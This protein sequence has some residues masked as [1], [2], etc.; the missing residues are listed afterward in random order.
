MPQPL[1]PT[2]TNPW[3][4]P[5][6]LLIV[7]HTQAANVAV[8]SQ[9]NAA[10]V[11]DS[12][13]ATI[14][15]LSQEPGGFTFS[16]PS[17]TRS[18]RLPGLQ[19]SMQ[20][21]GSQQRSQL[22]VSPSPESG[23]LTQLAALASSP[24][25]GLL[26]QLAVAAVE[27]GTPVQFGL[28][29]QYVPSSKAVDKDEGLL[30]LGLLTQLM[31]S[32]QLDQGQEG[33]EIREEEEDSQ[34]AELNMDD[35]IQ[36]AGEE[37]AW[38][39]DGCLPG[40]ESEGVDDEHAMR[41]DI[42]RS[43]GGPERALGPFSNEQLDMVAN[44]S[45][46]GSRDGTDPAPP[47][48]SSLRA[49]TASTSE[50]SHQQRVP[51][52]DGGCDLDGGGDGD[53]DATDAVRRGG[54]AAHGG[55]K[56]AIAAPFALLPLS[57]AALGLRRKASGSA[58]VS[59]AQAGTSASLLPPSAPVA[60][61]PM[62]MKPFKRPR[63]QNQERRGLDG[64]STGPGLLQL[65]GAES[66]DP[67]R[68]PLA[69]RGPTDAGGFDHESSE[70]IPLPKPLEEGDTLLPREQP[71]I[72]REEVKELPLPFKESCG[73]LAEVWDV[74]SV[75]SSD[76]EDDMDADVDRSS[77]GDH[78]RGAGDGRPDLDIVLSDVQQHVAGAD[79]SP[80][81]DPP[82]REQMIEALGLN[83]V[84]D[85]ASNDDDQPP[86]LMWEV[87]DSASEQGSE[88]S[89]NDGG[90]KHGALVQAP[91]ISPPALGTTELVPEAAPVIGGPGAIPGAG[92]GLALQRPPSPAL[93]W[94][95]FFPLGNGSTAC[96][97]ST[98]P[99]AAPFSGRSSPVIGASA[100]DYREGGPF[101]AFLRCSV[102]TKAP[103]TAM[104]PGTA[105]PPDSM[106]PGTDFP[107]RTPADVQAVTPPATAVARDLTA[108]LDQQMFLRGDA[109]CMGGMQPREVP[110]QQT[111]EGPSPSP[112]TQ[113][114]GQVERPSGS[115]KRQSIASQED[116]FRGLRGG[117]DAVSS[118]RLEGRDGSSPGG[119]EAGAWGARPAPESLPALPP[120]RLACC[121][122]GLRPREL[123]PTP[124]SAEASISTVHGL[125]RVVH[126]V[127]RFGGVTRLSSQA[128]PPR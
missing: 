61:D 21:N 103:S 29:S 100:A 108:E 109:V 125:P 55:E 7:S 76:E 115:Q 51:Q 98:T 43:D 39:Q 24:E 116:R 74:I 19:P 111:S 95:G 6:N 81:V 127:R 92:A 104:V 99:A 48:E 57:G 62:L 102:P 60:I 123:P 114:G 14:E 52:Y 90:T 56:P 5:Q 117:E 30:D 31:S 45:V 97:A 110:S 15:A 12:G 83:D 11:R 3:A 8:A 67:S 119:D 78:A 59:R 17:Q 16:V 120:P 122:I 112:S 37:D 32:E 33:E 38:D 77:G 64:G 44:P 75:S 27:M 50:A 94:G 40:S 4:G 105:L 26:S 89:G 36:W 65:G 42:S 73:S 121:P 101:A 66:I 88:G 124:S 22:G 35:E 70:V 13:R 93:K 34:S 1:T 69:V 106:V 20:F 49:Q 10:L 128:A 9:A 2:P 118:G 85:I 68:V 91:A 63:L 79:P 41:S 113:H 58:S 71:D 46:D 96:L 23:L 84:V 87:L 72:K 25:A 82:C 28:D 80:A 53:D 54:G 47:C 86:G 18:G 107:T 126:Q